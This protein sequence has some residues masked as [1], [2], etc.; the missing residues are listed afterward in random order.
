[1]NLRRIQVVTD[2]FE[3]GQ[4]VPCRQT[5]VPG[6]WPTRQKPM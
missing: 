4:P 5:T 1:M 6:S 3:S 2:A